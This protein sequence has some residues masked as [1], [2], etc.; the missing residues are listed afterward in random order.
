MIALIWLTLAWLAGWRWLHL[1][2][3][4]PAVL[5]EKPGTSPWPAILF[6][7]AASLWFGLLP[8]TWLTYALAGLFAAI[9]PQIV[10]P[11]LPADT[12]VMLA[13]AVWLV[14]PHLRR[15]AAA[16]RIPVKTT[17]RTLLP[18]NA[19]RRPGR[20][21]WATLIRSLQ[22]PASR[23]FLLPL[24]LWLL[25]AGLIMTGTFYRSDTL[26][27][28]GY[29]VFSDFAPH[30][31]LVSSFA[32]GSN[33]PTE[34]P[35][36]AN[37]GISYHFIFYFLCGNL[38]YLGLPLDWAINLPS[39]LGLLSFC[40]LLGLLAWQL[41]GR[42]AS[43]LLAPLLLFA[44]SS[45]AFFTFLGDL[46]RQYGAAP[47]AWPAIVGRLLSQ[48]V[49][50]GNT[51]NDSWGLW[52]VNVYANQRH[53]LP[54]LAIA[55]IVVFLFLPDLND[56]LKRRPPWRQLLLSRD[57][58]RVR[59]PDGWR[60]LGSA[61]LMC[62]LLPYFHGSVLVS[63]LLILGGM[64]IF[65][66]NRAAFVI[67]GAGS[68]ASTLLQSWIFAGQAT[69]VIRPSI[70]FG[71]IAPDRSFPG[72]LGYLLEMS[73]I[74][75][76]LICLVFWLRGRRRKVLLACFLLPLI[77]ALTVSLTPD[78]TVNHK[79]IMISFLFCNIYVADLLA[80]LWA[81]GESWR[82]KLVRPSLYVKAVA[83]RIA[84]I[85]LATLLM[86]TGFQEMIIL[87]NISQKTVT[88]DSA[89]PLVAWIIK[90]TASDAVFVTAPYHY[91]AFYLSGRATWLGHAYYAWS[92]GHD[93]GGRLAQEQFLLTGCGGD[94][95][96]VQDMV[97]AADLDYLIIDDTLREHDEFS[98]DETFF[99][100]HFAVVARFPELGRLVV[101]DLQQVIG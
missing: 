67:V 62:L 39:I 36:F 85:V 1:I 29:S 41:T 40:V 76:P 68:L 31:A 48:D 71:F 28:A 98:V 53:L 2:L 10:H 95:A 4:N 21:G 47:T 65:S 72:I 87:R 88:I 66:S 97:A 57:F 17:P 101:Y 13:V 86:V 60:R 70:L 6:R 14:W 80:M 22:D 11:L 75:L 5:L 49:F 42:R 15:A 92:A 32:Q 20:T 74:L 51:P 7:L 93:T 12:L 79:Y 30:T 27:H 94:L 96:A 91:N 25:L 89:S 82:Q 33:W 52:G 59:G 44:R 99:G 69:A 16:L 26:Y 61:L 78:V 35:H 18:H 56:G 43:Y 73:G 9:L 55:L 90:N 46:I 63:L 37:D 58:W 64:A 83:L 50:I 100:E 77:L 19:V 3:G 24:L 38:N 8:L 23:I 45:F 84:A 81:G 34:Y 54:G